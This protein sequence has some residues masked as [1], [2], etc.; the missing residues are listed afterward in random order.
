MVPSL[1]FTM[2]AFVAT[3]VIV[4]PQNT[5]GEVGLVF[6]PWVSE[7]EANAAVLRAGGRIAG[8]GRWSNAVIAYVADPDFYM[9]VRE[10]GAWFSVVASALCAP[11]D[12]FG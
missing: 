11:P 4:H 10:E 5:T 12:N 8:P 2:I 3:F 1:V 7:A 9:R 6:A